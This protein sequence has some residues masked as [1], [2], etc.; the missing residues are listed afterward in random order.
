[1][2]HLSRL[3]VY[4]GGPACGAPAWGGGAS[5]SG[6]GALPGGGYPAFAESLQS[7]KRELETSISNEPSMKHEAGGKYYALTGQ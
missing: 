3:A 7:C 5:P 4:A 2:G 1:M 6:V